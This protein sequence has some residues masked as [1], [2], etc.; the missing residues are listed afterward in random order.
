M[1]NIKWLMIP[2]LVIFLFQTGCQESQVAERPNIVFIL[3]DD[4]GY[5]DVKRFGGE[6]CKISTPHID[7]LAEEGMMFTNAVSYASVCVPSRISI[8]TGRYPF[9]FDNWDVGGP[10]GFIGPTFPDTTFTLGDMMKSSGY[11][12]TYIGK[13]HLGTQ[14]TTYNNKM[15]DI[16][17]VDYSKPLIVGPEEYGIEESFI[18]P[19]SLDMYPYVF[20]RNG[21]WVGNVTTSKG[22]SAFNRVGPAAENFE[23]TLVLETFC[24]EAETYIE[25]FSLKDKKSRKPFFMYLSLTSP[26]TPLSVTESFRGKSPIGLYGDFVMETDHSVGRIMDKLEE[27]GLSENTLVIVTSDHGPAPYAGRLAEATHNQLFRMEKEDGHYAR[28]PFR[29]CKFSIYEGGH[30]VP[31]VAR[32]PNVVPASTVCDRNIGLIDLMATLAEVIGYEFK[33]D[34]APDSFSFLS[35]LKSPESEATRTSCITESDFA[36]AVRNEEWKLVM[37]PTS[38]ANEYWEIEPMVNEAWNNALDRYGKKPGSY[39]ELKNVEFVQL[40]NL[41][42]DPAETTN[43]ADQHPEIVNE[44]FNLFSKQ[45]EN[46]RTRQ[47]EPLQNAVP[48]QTFKQVPEYIFE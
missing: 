41:S 45:V 13:W 17:T 7:R 43:V 2:G 33:N 42:Q 5:G 4:Q 37:S 11:A 34:Q 16:G 8:M 23:D 22:W 32:W 29:G 28:G 15:Q 39:E 35:L 21:Q 27:H 31:F 14:M 9:R 48:V 24:K 6:L 26:H 12:M 38:G 19:G 3:T 20:V 30:R 10:W 25:Q 1:K 40:Y 44:L 46:G 18:L 36:F 47:G